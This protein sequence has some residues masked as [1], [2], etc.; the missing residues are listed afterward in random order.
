MPALSLPFEF[1]WTLHVSY[2]FC[3][4]F[5]SN[6]KCSPHCRNLTHEGEEIATF[7]GRENKT[8]SR[9]GNA[10]RKMRKIE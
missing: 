7:E 4:H 3:I 10:K 6:D 1:F 9:F 2:S 5:F 8:L